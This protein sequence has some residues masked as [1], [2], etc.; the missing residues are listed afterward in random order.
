MEEEINR[1]YICWV[2]G[3]GYSY[4]DIKIVGLH[5]ICRDEKRDCQRICLDENHPARYWM[6]D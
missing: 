3:L 5:F 6:E 1:E 2:C 4:E